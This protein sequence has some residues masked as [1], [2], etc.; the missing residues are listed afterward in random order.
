M[1][2]TWFNLRGA[3]NFVVIAVLMFGLAYLFIEGWD[4]Q[5]Q[6][7]LQQAEQRTEQLLG[8][9]GYEYGR[10]LPDVFAGGRETTSGFG[11]YDRW[12]ERGR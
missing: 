12:A 2:R 3:F 4:A 8:Y 6:I 5:H 11:Y 7:D 9:G 1:I 10:R